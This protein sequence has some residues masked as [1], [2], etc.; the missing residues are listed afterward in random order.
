M[1]TIEVVT[2][3]IL[4]Y[5]LLTVGTFCKPELVD[6]KPNGMRYNVWTNLKFDF[7]FKK[8]LFSNLL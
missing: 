6:T 8:L 1:L 3:V 4:A 7:M 5:L 2:D